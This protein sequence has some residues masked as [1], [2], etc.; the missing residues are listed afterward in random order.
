MLDGEYQFP[1]GC[2]A[3]DGGPH[4]GYTIQDHEHTCGG[5]YLRTPERRQLKEARLMSRQ[6]SYQRQ[7]AQYHGRSG[8]KLLR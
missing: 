1:C 6:E 7:N 4:W 2:R 3:T 8:F 5:A